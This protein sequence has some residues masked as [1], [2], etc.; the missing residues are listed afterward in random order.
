M[1]N[2]K[3]TNWLDWLNRIPSHVIARSEATKQ[4]L[5]MRLLR[6]ARNDREGEGDQVIRKLG[7]RISGD[8][9]IR[10][11]QR[12]SEAHFFSRVSKSLRSIFDLRF[13]RINSTSSAVLV[14]ISRIRLISSEFLVTRSR[15]NSIP[16]VF[17]PTC[18]YVL[19]SLA[20]MLG[21]SSRI[22]LNSLR[23]ASIS[24][25]TS[26]RLNLLFFL[27]CFFIGNSLMEGRPFVNKKIG[28]EKR[29]LSRSRIFAGP[30]NMQIFGAFVERDSERG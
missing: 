11:A 19:S 17:L 16:S 10:N 14:T 4:S 12:A 6:F 15:S 28:M 9:G 30:L 13:S 25:P 7:T 27:A 18:S 23:M 8:W 20:L 29:V 21:M 26:V 2:K 22:G 24:T 1:G 5:F 3:I